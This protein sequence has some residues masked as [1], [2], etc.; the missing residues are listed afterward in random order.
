MCYGFRF[1]L[2]IR[3]VEKRVSLYKFS[4]KIHTDT[5]YFMY[6]PYVLKFHYQDRFS[7]CVVFIGVDEGNLF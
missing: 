1:D 6:V 5:M 4:I 3:Y 2:E 7:F